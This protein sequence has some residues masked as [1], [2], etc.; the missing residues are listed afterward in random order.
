[1]VQ[2]GHMIHAVF[3]HRNLRVGLVINRLRQVDRLGVFENN[4]RAGQFAICLYF[5][6]R[7]GAF[8]G[9]Q[10]AARVFRLARHPAP[11]RKIERYLDVLNGR[12]IHSPQMERVRLHAIRFHV[13]IQI[14]GNRHQQEPKPRAIGQRLH[15]GFFP[16]RRTRVFRP[17]ACLR[18]IE[19]NQFRRHH[20]VR[21][22]PNSARARLHTDRIVRLQPSLGIA[23]PK[24]RS[25][26]AEHT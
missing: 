19:P 11:R 7:H 16:F 4:P 18:G 22:A 14:F 3:L 26:I 9:S 8:H 24:Q 13:I 1:M 10:I 17:E 20:L 2:N 15:R 6:A 25:A 21:L 23:A 12:Q 5:Q